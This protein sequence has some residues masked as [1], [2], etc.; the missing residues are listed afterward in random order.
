MLIFRPI[1]ETKRKA[2][3]P[4]EIGIRVC[5]CFVLRGVKN[6]E[7]VLTDLERSSKPEIFRVVRAE[8]SKL[9]GMGNFGET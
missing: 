8:N 6:R 2:K 5:R 4:E 7:K 9:R 1:K 3:T